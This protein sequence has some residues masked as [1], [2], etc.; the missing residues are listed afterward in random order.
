MQDGQITED[1]ILEP[2]SVIKHPE[3][4]RT[5]RDQI[6]VAG[7]T[8]VAVQDIQIAKMVALA[9]QRKNETE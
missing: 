7:L 8:G 2:G 3:K 4:G 9:Y 5:D 6:T 1:S